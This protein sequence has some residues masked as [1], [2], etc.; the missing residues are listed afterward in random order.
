MPVHVVDHMRVAGLPARCIRIVG[1]RGDGRFF[2]A[3]PPFIA[4]IGGDGG[5]AFRGARMFE[6]A[7]RIAVIRGA[8]PAAGRF[9]GR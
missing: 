2:R 4:V 6:R 8:A 5:A 7:V 9:A 1:V 3:V